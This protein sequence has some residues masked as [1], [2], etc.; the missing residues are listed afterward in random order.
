[1]STHQKSEFRKQL[2]NAISPAMFYFSLVFLAIVAALLVLWIDV[3]RV[4]EFNDL[5]ATSEF[6]Q[7]LD[8]PLH[9]ESLRDESKSGTESLLS[10]AA[11]QLLDQEQEAAFQSTAATLSRWLARLLGVI[12]LVVIAEQLAYLVLLDNWQQYR[13]DH[14]YS[15]AICLVPPL[16]LCSRHSEAGGQIWFPVLGWQQPSPAFQREMERHTSLP[17]IGIA[18]LILPVL[19][20]QM[21]Y[22]AAIVQHPWLRVALHIGT[23]LIWFA[24]ATEFLVMVS[25]TDKKLRYCKKHWLDLVI[26]LL[27]LISFLRTW[28]MLRASKLIKF[29]KLQQLSK[30]IR[31]YRL[32]GVTMRALRALLVLD[33]LQRILRTKPERRLAKLEELYAEKEA[34]L[35]ML[36]DEIEQLR[37]SANL[38]STSN[39]TSLQSKSAQLSA[40]QSKSMD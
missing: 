13:A 14:P 33:I 17:M 1:M 34:E 32:R 30:I 3:P 36:R 16:R 7:M 10:K 4:I 27:P 5:D 23:G 11:L 26:I 29:S 22:G 19:G 20:L 12:W 21:I 15:L 2:R 39:I 9:D 37:S 25:V 18:L 38:L 8:E 28:Q 35:A 6:E 31:A 40:S 24:F